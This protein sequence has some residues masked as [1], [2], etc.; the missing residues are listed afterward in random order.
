MKNF[1]KRVDWKR[2]WRFELYSFIIIMVLY[3]N[4]LGNGRNTFPENIYI[5][6][7]FPVFFGLAMLIRTHIEYL[8]EKENVTRTKRRKSN[9]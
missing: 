3:L 4:S 2:F 9:S 7:L 8:I 6:P 5:I 1:I